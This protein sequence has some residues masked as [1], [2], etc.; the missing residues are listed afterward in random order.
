[1]H[2]QI[3]I[4]IPCF[5]EEQNLETTVISLKR[6]L[7]GSQVTYSIVIVDDYSTDNTFRVAKRVEGQYVKVKRLE[8]NSGKGAAIK[9]GIKY[10]DTDFVSYVDADGDIL[11]D[12][13]LR[14]YQLL[15]ANEDLSACLGSK[16]HPESKV[17]YPRTRVLLS[18]IFSLY[19]R[20]LFNLNIKDTQTGVKVF[21]KSDLDGVIESLFSEG[22]AFDLELCVKLNARG[23][24]M[25]EIPVDIK[26]SFDSTVNLQSAFLAIKDTLKIKLDLLR[27]T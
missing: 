20:L 12:S 15:L 26:H 7:E 27:A 21:R 14:G 10:L 5:N 9:H 22:F 1:M 19:I 11:V 17:E 23:A 6:A 18:K 24:K 3:G 16:R 8:R 25:I 4:V 13:I 2:R